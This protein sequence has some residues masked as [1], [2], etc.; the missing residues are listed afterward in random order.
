MQ[1]NDYNIELQ[2]MSIENLYNWGINNCDGFE[3]VIL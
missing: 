1:N 2:N 3:F